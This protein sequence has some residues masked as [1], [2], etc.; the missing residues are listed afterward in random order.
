[1]K[2]H[3]R[4]QYVKLW[5]ANYWRITMTKKFELTGYQLKMIGIVL[6]VGDHIHEMFI[7]A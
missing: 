5:I 6:V 1:M 2:V 7:Y 4:I 3:P